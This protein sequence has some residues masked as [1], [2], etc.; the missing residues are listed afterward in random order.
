MII[1]W[2][3]RKSTSQP[4]TPTPRASETMLTSVTVA[5]RSRTAIRFDER[6]RSRGSQL[7]EDGVPQSTRT[8][9]KFPCNPIMTSTSGIMRDPAGLQHMHQ[10]IRLATVSTT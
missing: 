5:R 6:R 8:F 9:R 10:P 2:W 3:T 1:G 7:L 4:I